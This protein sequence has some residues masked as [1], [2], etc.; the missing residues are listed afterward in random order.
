MKK[1]LILIVLGLSLGSC[2]EYQKAFKSEDT[3]FQKK[4]A[5]NLY[6]KKQRN[7]RQKAS[8]DALK[9]VLMEPP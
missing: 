6:E 9:M 3:E 1:Q 4:V 2:S 5:K 8:G 7:I